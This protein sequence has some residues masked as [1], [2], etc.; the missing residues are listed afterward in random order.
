MAGGPDTSAPISRKVGGPEKRDRSGRS[1]RRQPI[2]EGLSRVFVSCERGQSRDVLQQNSTALQVENAVFTPLLQLPI[3]AF[4]RR[5][6]EDPKLLLRDV[7]LG[8]EILR[9]R[10]KPARQPD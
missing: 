10:A 2:D 8:A 9:E 4:A 3:H 7:H 1:R 6:N 5:T